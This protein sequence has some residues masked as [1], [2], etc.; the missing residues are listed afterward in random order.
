MDFSARGEYSACE[1]SIFAILKPYGTACVKYAKNPRGIRRQEHLWAREALSTHKEASLFRSSVGTPG[2]GK[3]T[4]AKIYAN[5]LH[6]QLFELSAVSA[7][8][9]DI[10]VLLTRGKLFRDKSFVSRRESVQQ[11]P[12]GFFPPYVE[13]GELVLIGA[14]TENQLRSD[15]GAS[16]ALRLFVC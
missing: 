15:F 5:S 10:K 8:K 9:D 2:V 14:T 1:G 12:T 11:G 13:R 6:A 3:T 16:F 4:L 7:G